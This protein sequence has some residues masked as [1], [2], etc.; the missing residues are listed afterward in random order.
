MLDDNLFAPHVVKDF[1]CALLTVHVICGP[2]VGS[3][4]HLFGIGSPRHGE[5]RI[6]VMRFGH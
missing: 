3:V 4:K 5:C 2:S 1:M 6:L